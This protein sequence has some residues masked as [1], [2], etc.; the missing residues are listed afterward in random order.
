MR[1]LGQDELTAMMGIGYLGEVRRGPDGAAYQWV[2][3]VDGLG[4][5]VGIWKKLKK[6]ARRAAPF[7]VPGG[8]AV[9]IG[10][11]LLREPVLRR[12]ATQALPFVPGVGPAAAAALRS[13]TPLLQRAGVAVPVATPAAAVPVAVP[14]EAAPAVAAYGGLGAL[15]QAPDGTLYQMQGFAEDEE[16]RGFAEEEEL[17]GL[18]ALYQA[19]DGTLY[20]V[21]GLAEDE[22][23]RGLVEDE[24]L[25]GFAGD[26]ELRGFAEDEELRGFAEDEELRGLAEAEELRGF[27]EEDELRGLDQGYVRARPGACCCPGAGPVRTVSGLEAYVPEQPARTRWFQPPGCTPKLFEPNW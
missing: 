16:L 27:A 10:K 24:E 19:P 9:A 21:Q 4:N 1:Y 25:R 13:A 20:Q 2:E 15:Y 14:T 7:V 18:G 8:A 17:H 5:P 26:E 11:R 23:L 12:L 6:F 22:E 3:G